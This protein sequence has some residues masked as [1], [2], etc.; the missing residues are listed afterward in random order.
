MD[1]PAVE[2]ITGTGEHMDGEILLQSAFWGQFKAS[3]G[4]QPRRFACD[5][6]PVLVLIRPLA[7]GLS[8]AYVPHGPSL[9][10]T[11]DPGEFLAGLG[12]G[13]SE[14]LPGGCFCIRFDLPDQASPCLLSNLEGARGIEKAPVDIQPPDTVVLSLEAGEDEILK[15][16][17]SKTRYNIRLS[18]KKGVRIVEGGEDDLDDWYAL[19]EETGRRDR[20]ALHSRD[21]FGTLFSLARSFGE[22]APVVRLLFAEAEGERVAA[23]IV[24]RY[25]SS[26]TYLYGASSGLYRNYMPAYGLQWYAMTTEKQAGSRSYDLFGIPPADDPDHPMHGLYRFKTGFGG[27]ILKRPGCW[28]LPLRPGIYRLYRGAEGM[29]NYYFKV[30][31]KRTND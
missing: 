8:L 10:G 17:K 16:M 13:L 11:A 2:E 26:S 15:G 23:V 18:K 9:E 1:T 27:R 30:L 24:G 21:Y 7:A 19:F 29:R 6:K 4:W 28:D 20:I 22:G 12:H 3:F 14:F 31:K 5:G 25:R